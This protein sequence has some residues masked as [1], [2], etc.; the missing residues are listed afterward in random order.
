MDQYNKSTM[1]LK[2][3][4]LQW[5]TIT[6]ITHLTC[7]TFEIFKMSEMGFKRTKYKAYENNDNESC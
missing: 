7:A 1:D 5:K 2:K 4:K 3:S 6:K